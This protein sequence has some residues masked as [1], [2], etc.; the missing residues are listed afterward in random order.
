M[1]FSQRGAENGVRIPR[2]GKRFW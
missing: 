2:E 1:K